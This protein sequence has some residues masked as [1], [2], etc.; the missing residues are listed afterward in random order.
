MSV[1]IPLSADINPAGFETVRKYL[2][3]IAARSGMTEKE[4]NDM[5]KAIEDTGKK[6]IKSSNEIKKSFNEVDRTA[7]KLGST[8]IAVFSVRALWQYQQQIIKTGA[9]F[10][11]LGAMIE[12]ALGD[13]SKANR[14]MQMIRNFA[15][16]TP[17]QVQNITEAFIT[18]ASDGFEPTNEELR[19]MGD[20][21]AAR[22][23][24]IT[25]WAN[26]IRNAVTG[27]FEML[28]GFGVRTKVEGD[29]AKFTFRGIT[30]EVQNSEKAIRDYLLSLG[31]YEGVA[32]GMARVSET[33]GGKI[34]NLSDAFDSLFAN[35]AEAES[36]IL[37][38]IYDW[39]IDFVNLAALAVQSV[40]Q[41]KAA[42]RDGVTAAVI[43]QDKKEL[44]ELVEKYKQWYD[45]TEAVDKATQA[46]ISSFRNLIKSGDNLTEQEQ[47]LNEQYAERIQALESASKSM[48]G[49][50]R[51]TDEKN[52]KEIEKLGI[53]GQLEKDISELRKQRAMAGST[54]EIARIDARIAKLRQ[55][56]ALVN[57]LS[58]Y[59]EGPE[60]TSPFAG[61]E[62]ETQSAFD[63]ANA[64][65]AKGFKKFIETE[66]EALA[67]RKRIN[68]FFEQYRE[69]LLFE[70]LE[71]AR[72]VGN[73]IADVFINNSM[74]NIQA[75]E[76][77]KSERLR[78]AGED[79]EQ[80]ELIESEFQEKIRQ[81]KIKAARADKI[82]AL[83]DIALNTAVAITRTKR[84]LGL[85]LALPFI[86]LAAA[87]GAAQAAVVASR[88]IPGFKDGIFDL[89]GPG[90]SKSDSIP[91]RLSKGE[92]VVHAEGTK[93]FA[94][95]IRPIIE[96]KNMTYEKLMAIMMNKVPTRLRGDIM[97]PASKE[98]QDPRVLSELQMI[99]RA[100]KD[101]EKTSVVI[102][103]TG[104]SVRNA[105]R[106]RV[107]KQMNDFLYG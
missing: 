69:Q 34:S 7:S 31:D 39:M 8:L 83:F 3:E 106:G 36:G 47:R 102:D 43:E 2:N 40:D 30:T 52:N 104:V 63:K 93:K 96:D 24:D 64:A 66:K 60:R 82:A 16:T 71:T 74:R 68:E 85:P 80:R 5:N 84:N 54:E 42:A 28:K 65:A 70:S 21:A 97:K 56:L 91:A 77:E 103:Q 67:E 17:F 86:A 58:G 105:K 88:P 94:D 49:L 18:L 29:I 101:S 19:K 76:T 10:Q 22:G 35:L 45:E 14:A 72:Q 6:G 13:Q 73:A 59:I 89:D 11:K 100:I 81:E 98:S 79:A 87:Q 107:I 32:G 90:S 53:I 12:T 25:E 46:M 92:S 9:E 33:L 23:R 41:I 26:A 62:A 75:L 48:V 50:D 15:S 95:I 51:V 57:L 37:I 20:L 27:Q 44:E 4:I 99:R 38:K 61:I 78:I 1:N 55:E